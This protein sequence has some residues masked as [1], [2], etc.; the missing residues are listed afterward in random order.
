[1]DPDTIKD[2][3]LKYCMNNLS[4]NVPEK[5]VAH[6]IKERRRYQEQNIMIKKIKMRNNLT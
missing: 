6:L 5:D 3:T 1:M 2:I 4:Q